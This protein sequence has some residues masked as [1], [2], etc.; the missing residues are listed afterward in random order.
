MTIKE[1]AREEYPYI[2]PS[3]GYEC[4]DYNEAA[5]DGFI[6]GAKW[7][8]EKAADWIGNY[9]MEIGYPDDWLRDSPNMKSGEE[10]FI[11]AMEE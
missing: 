10:R 5:K 8:L 6:E 7:M 9:L 11:K 1:K 4:H 3:D 2:T